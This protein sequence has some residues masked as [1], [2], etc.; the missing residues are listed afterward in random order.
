MHTPVF[1]YKSGV[2]GV[3]IT[4]TCFPDDTFSVYYLQTKPGARTRDR[5]PP[6]KKPP[7]PQNATKKTNQYGDNVYYTPEMVNGHHYDARDA[8]LEVRLKRDEI[9]DCGSVIKTETTNA[10]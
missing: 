6:A 5:R 8:F 2:Q 4:G 9:N 3:Y 10:F 7:P 1:L